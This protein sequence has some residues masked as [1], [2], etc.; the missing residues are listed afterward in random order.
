MIVGEV[1]IKLKKRGCG[2][3]KVCVGNPF[4]NLALKGRKER[5]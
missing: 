3:D 1:E 5:Q 4:I 2:Q